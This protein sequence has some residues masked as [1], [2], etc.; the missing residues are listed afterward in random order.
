M[1][2]SIIAIALAAATILSGCK[3]ETPT[4]TVTVNIDDS[5]LESN[6]TKP[7]VYQVSL[8]NTAGAVTYN[9]ESEN[10]VAVFPNMI[11]GIYNIVVTAN[12]VTGATSYV[13]SGSEN[14]VSVL[15]DYT[16][17]VAVTATKA[18]SL[19]FKEI[20]YCGAPGDGY[21]FRDQF[22]EIYN[23]G[24]E[25]VYADG[26]CIST[27]EFANYNFTTMYEYDIP[28]PENYVFCKTI[29]QI[30]G[31]GT[32]YPVKPGESIVIAQWATDHTAASLSA[33][34]SVMNLT[35]A[36]FE[37]IEAESTLW[38]GIVITDNP[39]VNMAKVVESGY[40]MPQ[41]LTSVS[42]AAY[43]IFN[44]SQPLKNE[45][46]IAVTNASSTQLREVLI[47]DVIDAVQTG[48]D[49]T[50]A[51]TLGLP[52]SLDAGFQHLDGNYLGKS[53]SR[54]LAETREDGVK[55]YKDTNNT[56]ED[57]QINETPAVRRDGVGVPSWNTWIK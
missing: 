44:P 46:F 29:W 41:W 28:N 34:M 12:T 26:L 48:A 54:K 57:F 6:V 1:K 24:T 27:L 36:E 31:T 5:A 49:E 23:Q 7:E 18:S 32:Q 39:A 55:V 19:V 4:Y 47:S 21:Y 9:A 51:T 14:T 3:K 56:T 38:N 13:V 43:I 37:A 17:T 10:G 22:Y 8:T 20:Y 40:A 25:T 15:A 2:K 52:T 50:R 11:S 33:G 45:D 16:T 53:I 35:G 42:G 30:P